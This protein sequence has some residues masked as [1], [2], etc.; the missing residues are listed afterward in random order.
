MQKTF[1]AEI[2]GKISK[3]VFETF[4][5][6]DAVLAEIRERSTS[7]GLPEI[8]VGTMD[9]LHLEVLTRLAG[10]RKVVEIGTL[11]GYSGVAILRG[12]GPQGK[13]WT[14]E[15][16]PKHAEVARETFA[17][18]GFSGQV[19]LHVGAASE[20]LSKIEK[21]GP[22]DLVFVDADKVSYPAYLEWAAQNLRVGGAV[23][24]DNTFAWGMIADERFETSEDEAAVRALRKFN[25]QAAS[26]RGRFRTTILPTGEG[27]TVAVKTR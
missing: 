8:Q 9:A 21:D 7:R 10:A 17:K 13:L 16:E 24:G 6:E 18:A 26:V 1:S 20:N 4:H 15:Y 19:E 3:Y 14:F 25:E 2:S 11:G 5:P 27:L 12:M 23:L 22:F